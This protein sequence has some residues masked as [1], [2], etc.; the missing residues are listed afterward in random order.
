VNGTW[1]VIEHR[2]LDPGGAIVLDLGRSDWADWS[3]SGELLYARDGCV[4][5]AVPGS[6]G[7]LRTPEQLID[8]RALRFEQVPPTTEATTW[9]LRVAGRQI[10]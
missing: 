10:R 2:V 9:H 4:Y 7:C 8:L 5:R 1:Y 6:Q 3:L